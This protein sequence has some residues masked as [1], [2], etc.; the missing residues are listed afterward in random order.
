MISLFLAAPAPRVPGA[1]LELL[2]WASLELYQ[3][4]GQPEAPP[5]LAMRGNIFKIFDNS[6]Q[7]VPT[8]LS[9]H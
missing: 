4:E 3:V 6:G 9:K 1:D 5:W 2:I 7:L 8:S